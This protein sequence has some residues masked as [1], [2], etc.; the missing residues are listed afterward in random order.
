M[1]IASLY[2]IMLIGLVVLPL[3]FIKVVPDGFQTSLDFSEQIYGPF[4]VEQTF[5]VDKNYLSGLALTIRNP[6]ANKSDLNFKLRDSQGQI[7]RHKSLH[8]ANIPDGDFVKFNFEPITDS[9]DRQFNLVL[10]SV[11]STQ[12]QAFGVYMS[13]QMSPGFEPIRVKGEVKNGQMA[14]LEYYGY[15]NKLVQIWAVLSDFSKRFYSDVI[16]GI[17][18]TV[19]IIYLISALIYSPYLKRR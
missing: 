2:T 3:L 12:E 19:S 18:F 7:L 5:S 13:K 15:P 14:I 17:I 9:K 6:S 8:G 10:E 16:F 11:D 4:V 1:K